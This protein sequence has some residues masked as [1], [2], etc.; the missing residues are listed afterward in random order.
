MTLDL[1]Q[2]TLIKGGY[3]E[4]QAFAVAKDLMAVALPLQPLLQSWISEGTETDFTADRFSIL[5]LK[6]RF[7]MTYP[8]ALLSIDW[9]LKDPEIAVRAISRGIR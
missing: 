4:K 1:I 3:P 8:A 2:S 5:E 7:N 6:K 9:V